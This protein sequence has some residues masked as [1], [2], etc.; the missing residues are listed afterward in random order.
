MGMRH[1]TFEIPDEVAQDFENRVPPSE[2]SC[3]VT[4]LLQ[5]SVSSPMLTEDEWNEA[6]KSAN[7]DELLKA[8]IQEWQA[9]SDPIE[10]PWDAPSP[11]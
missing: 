2:Q 11:R 8:D 9:F 3:F 4:H 1:M 7:A 6:S 10:E 5:H